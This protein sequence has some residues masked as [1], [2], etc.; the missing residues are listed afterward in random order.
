MS[1]CRALPAE[2]LDRPLFGAIRDHSL[3]SNNE[4]VAHSLAVS[5]KLSMFSTFSSCFS[6]LYTYSYQ[7]VVINEAYLNFSSYSTRHHSSK[8]T[9]SIT[10]AQQNTNISAHLRYYPW[11]WTLLLQFSTFLF[12]FCV[13]TITFYLYLLLHCDVFSCIIGFIMTCC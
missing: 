3:S 1:R 9:Q 10:H 6:R 13:I 8:R 12:Y 4:Y 5:Q 2:Q 11:L 7:Y